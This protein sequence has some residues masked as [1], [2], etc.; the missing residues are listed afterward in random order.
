MTLY[1]ARGVANG[2]TRGVGLLVRIVRQIIIFCIIIFFCYINTCGERDSANTFIGYETM[3]TE[4]RSPTISTA[5]ITAYTAS[6]AECGKEDGITAS[7]EL[8]TEGITVAADHLPLGTKVLIDG[9]IY[10]V[11]DRFGGNYRDR[12]DIYMESVSRA[13]EYGRQFK[14][15]EIIKE[16]N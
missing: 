7:G 3:C 4:Y 6:I 13:M 12:I 11:Q 15:I 2:K 10:T 1:N 14:E 16:V 9:N 5:N 8:A